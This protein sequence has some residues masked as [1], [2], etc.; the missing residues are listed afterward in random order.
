MMMFFHTCI[1]LMITLNNYFH[2]FSE[3]NF[4]F[5]MVPISLQL[6]VTLRVAG[7]VGS[8]QKEMILTG[9]DG[10]VKRLH[11]P[12]VRPMIIPD[13]QK[14]VGYTIQSNPI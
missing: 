13:R 1:L 9:S 7:V 5:N 10:E 3:L 14:P 6:I 4:I 11:Q 2:L 8:T 12:Q